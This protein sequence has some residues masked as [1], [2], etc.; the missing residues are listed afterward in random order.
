[1]L[2]I[3]KWVSWNALEMR[4]R[5]YTCHV[6]E[7][8]CLLIRLILACILFMLNL[9]EILILNIFIYFEQ[10]AF[11]EGKLLASINLWMNSA[12]T[13]SSTHYDPHHNLLCIISGCKQGM[14]I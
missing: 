11:L 10:P 2:K 1:M 6:S 14:E 13:R 3:R 9:G 4:L 12:R 7:F 8:L 5:W